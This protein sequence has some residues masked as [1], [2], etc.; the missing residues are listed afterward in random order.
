LTNWSTYGNFAFVYVGYIRFL[1]S[2]VFHNSTVC[3]LVSRVQWCVPATSALVERRPVFSQ[4]GV[5]IWPHWAR[6]SDE[7]LFF[8]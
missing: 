8:I 5:I 7:I 1:P 2:T 4:S 3:G 6:M